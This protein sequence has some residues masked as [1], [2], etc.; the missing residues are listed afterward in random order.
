MNAANTEMPAGIHQ[1]MIIL[2]AAMN[3]VMTNMNL[4]SERCLFIYE[5]PCNIN[6]NIL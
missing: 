6:C 4:R 1:R 3:R 5:S 2:N